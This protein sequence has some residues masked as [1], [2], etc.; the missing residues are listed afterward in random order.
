MNP[1]NLLSNQPAPAYPL[2][3]TEPLEQ[4]PSNAKPLLDKPG[5]SL[6]DPITFDDSDVEDERA[7]VRRVISPSLSPPP[8]TDNDAPLSTTAERV[9]RRC[10]RPAAEYRQPTL[11]S[12]DDL[13]PTELYEVSLRSDIA[14][15]LCFQQL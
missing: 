1:F 10:P 7:P 14:S 5:N 2:V 12:L 3:K 11:V 13:R 8:Q 4:P 6:E 15:R 9:Y